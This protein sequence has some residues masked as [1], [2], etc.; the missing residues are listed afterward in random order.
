M[1]DSIARPPQSRAN[2]AGSRRSGSRGRDSELHKIVS[3]THLDDHSQYH[4][5]HFHDNYN[6]DSADDEDSSDDTE[7]S[8]KETEDPNELEAGTNEDIVS[9]VRDGIEDERDVENLGNLEK[10]RTSRSA[11]SARDPNLVTWDGPEDPANPKNWTNKHKWA[12]TVIGMISYT[13]WGL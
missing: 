12:A 8:E 6:H 9:E 11:R 2:T 10:K 3:G 1:A 13:S 5:H 7:L 4:G